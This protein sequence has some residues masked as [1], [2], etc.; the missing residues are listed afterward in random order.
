MTEIDLGTL[1][2]ESFRVWQALKQELREGAKLSEIALGQHAPNQ[3]T[4]ATEITS[5]TQSGS[6]MIRSMARTIETRFLE[7]VLTLVWQTALQHMDFAAI[8]DEIGEET[9]A[10]LNTQRE[11]FRDSK[12]RFRVRGISELIDRNS[13]LRSLLSMLQVVGQNEVLLTTF[14]EKVDAGKLLD[15]MFQL[16]GVDVLSLQL[17]PQERALRQFPTA[18]APGGQPAPQQ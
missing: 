4:T 13:Q 1:P 18:A 14:L 8:A 12:I 2:A 5:V 6:A 16:F 10:M 7:P 17:T 3:G 15:Q 9:A 11:E